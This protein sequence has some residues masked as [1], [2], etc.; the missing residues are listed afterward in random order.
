[1]SN[2][3]CL[4]TEAQAS[5]KPTCL[6]G[7]PSDLEY[8]LC[9]YGCRII[10]QA[11]IL[12]RLPQRAMSTAQ[13]LFQRFW[14]VSSMKQFDELDIAMG[15]ILLASKIQEVPA[16]IRD[17]HLVF[18]FLEQYER[19]KAR[20][21]SDGPTSPRG[22]KKTKEPPN[23]HYKPF[24][25]HGNIYYDAKDALVIAE[26][27]LLKRLGFDV[28][29]NLPHAIMINY[30]QVLGVVEKEIDALG[31]RK[32]VAQLA[33]NYLNDALQSPVY[34]LFPPH[35]I[36]CASI[37]LLT[38]DSV[39]FHEPLALP[40]QPAPWWTLFDVDR[41]ELRVV[42]SHILQLYEANPMPSALA[43]LNRKQALIDLTTRSGIRAW[44]QQT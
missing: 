11:G 43:R 6:D 14:F 22:P 17:V 7:V 20:H 15:S 19:Y 32:K 34:C 39:H 23:F 33:W 2:L 25:S 3:N 36:A 4:A 21:A 31:T 38:V 12:L 44:L 24:A 26:M 42:S 1:M 28:Q 13:V 37:Y 8:S 30:M 29:V 27:Q 41:D 35:V 9:A 18:D 40:M 16:R 5:L 10:Q